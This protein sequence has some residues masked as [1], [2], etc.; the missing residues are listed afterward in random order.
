MNE[1]IR[2]GDVVLFKAPGMTAFYRP[3]NTRHDLPAGSPLRAMDAFLVS[4]EVQDVADEAARDIA[5]DAQNLALAEGLVRTGRYARSFDSAPGELKVLPG[6][7]PNPRRS[8]IVYN[9]VPQAVELELGMDNRAT[10]KPAYRILSRAAEPYQS[11][12]A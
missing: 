8:A 11:G 9:D 7:Y 2:P 6:E 4:Q 1:R 12:G 10:Q 5:R 3:S